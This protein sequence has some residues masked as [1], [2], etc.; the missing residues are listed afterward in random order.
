MLSIGARRC[1]A[2]SCKAQAQAGLL[3]DAQQTFQ[4]A[5]QT[6]QPIEEA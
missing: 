5:L 6:A 2:T 1:A 4:Q 3:E